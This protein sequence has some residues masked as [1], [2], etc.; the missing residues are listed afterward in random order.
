MEGASRSI[1]GG[2]AVSGLIAWVIDDFGLA[3]LGAE[4]RRDLLEIIDD[5]HG[6]RST[7]VTSQFPV[8]KWHAVM[9]YQDS[10]SARCFSNKSL[11]A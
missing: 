3:R 5:R 10:I 7:I 8:E 1:R 4:N 6:M 2:V 11:R 9:E